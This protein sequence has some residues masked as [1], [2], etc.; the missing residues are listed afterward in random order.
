MSRDLGAF[1]AESGAVVGGGAVLGATLGFM[2]GSLLHDFVPG[3]DPDEWARQG[4][5]FGGLAGLVA[6]VERA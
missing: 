1:L 6:L 2:V 5:F 3:V 4:G